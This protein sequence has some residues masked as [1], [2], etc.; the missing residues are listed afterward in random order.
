MNTINNDT[1]TFPGIT[2]GISQ[3][4]TENI[5]TD[6]TPLRL[7]VQSTVAEK[8]SHT[9]ISQETT[10]EINYQKLATEHAEIIAQGKTSLE[11]AQWIGDKLNI[12]SWKAGEFY[13][14]RKVLSSPKTAEESARL[15]KFVEALGKT[16]TKAN[17]PSEHHPQYLLLDGYVQNA[18]FGLVNMAQ[19]DT[20]LNRFHI[21]W[22]RMWWDYTTKA[23]YLL[24]E[25]GLDIKSGWFK[26]TG[27]RNSDGGFDSD[28]LY[29]CGSLDG[30]YVRFLWVGQ[31]DSFVQHH[32]ASRAFLCFLA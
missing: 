24:K 12:P 31:Y 21:Y 22:Q 29:A 25:V 5:N 8:L 27:F 23:K 3:P 26:L 14:E 9:E 7:E 1:G 16:W 15:Q 13:W 28:G 19:V 10:K 32:F 18:L 30:D 6:T 4:H 20:R 2:A 11:I 17:Q